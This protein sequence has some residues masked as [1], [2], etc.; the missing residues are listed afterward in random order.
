MSKLK[1]NS[2][3]LGMVATNCYFVQNQETA[4]LLIVDP[5]DSPELIEQQVQKMGGRVCAIL[6]THGHFDHMAAADACRRKFGVSVYACSQE[7]QVLENPSYNLS[8]LWAEPITLEADVYVEDGLGLSLAGFDIQVLH[9]PGH[10]AGSV[11]YYLEEERTLLS[12]DTLFDG[13]YGRT[14]LPTASMRQMRESIR[15]LLELPGDTAV[16]PGHGASTEI[17]EEKRYNPLA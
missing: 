1:I 7:R 11:C 4:E 17:A 8:G 13:S 10:T 3:V 14:D 9:T 12:G 6:L 15:R 5:A 2:L 16:Y